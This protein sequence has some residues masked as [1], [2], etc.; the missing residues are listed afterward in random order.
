ML[1]LTKWGR[2]TLACTVEAAATNIA[3]SSTFLFIVFWLYFF[4]LRKGNSKRVKKQIKTTKIWLCHKKS[5]HL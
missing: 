3:K 5:V 2:R 4:L 1:S